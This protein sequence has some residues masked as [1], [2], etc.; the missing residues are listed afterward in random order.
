MTCRVYNFMTP[1]SKCQMSQSGKNCPC[2]LKMKL[3]N[4]IN[5]V[6]RYS[7][8]TTRKL[9]PELPRI[10]FIPVF[11][12]LNFIQFKIH[13]SYLQKLR[14]LCIFFFTKHQMS[15]L[16]DNFAV[17]LYTLSQ[18]HLFEQKSQQVTDSPGEFFSQTLVLI[19]IFLGIFQKTDSCVVTYWVVKIII[20][21]LRGL[22]LS[23][24]FKSY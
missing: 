16:K 8:L 7:S 19:C 2:F 21:P 17:F 4:L 6:V 12:V 3:E 15:T 23:S 13:L 22:V 14:S 24:S 1:F 5:A 9:T 18:M 11:C 20:V 10:S